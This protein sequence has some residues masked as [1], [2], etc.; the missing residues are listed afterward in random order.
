MAVGKDRERLCERAVS[1]IQTYAD[2]VDTVC[3]S[4]AAALPQDQPGHSADNP[5]Q[6]IPG[7][8]IRWKE[9]WSCFF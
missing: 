3:V 8:K 5:K 2:T 6:Q 1:R 4:A 7:R 9:R